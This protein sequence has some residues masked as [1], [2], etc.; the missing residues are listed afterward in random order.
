[1]QYA[2][3]LPNPKSIVVPVVALAIGAAA[4]TGTYAL[5]DSEQVQL[6]SPKVI[7]TEAP[8]QPSQGLAAKNE[9]ATAA[10]IASRL[11][12]SSFGK[13]E[14]GT[15]AAISAGTTSV[16][17]EGVNA[18]NEAGTA[19]AL[20]TGA[21]SSGSEGVN[22][23]NEAGTAAALGSG[24][25]STG[26]A[27]GI[28]SPAAAA[29]MNGDAGSGTA[30]K[31]EAGTAAAIGSGVEPRGSKATS[32]SGSEGVNAKNEAG[33]AAAIGNGN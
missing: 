16:G 6:Q 3:R 32:T 22:A 18:K 8:A 15:A 31:D 1:M 12:S 17:S 5:I 21:T 33:T 7:V 2:E 20:S 26:S 30:S 24:V 11:P 25:T 27:V 13:D 29:K 9:A 19:A 14:A 10:A 23:K 4:A 28:P